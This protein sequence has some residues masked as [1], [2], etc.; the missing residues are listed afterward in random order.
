[1]IE[2]YAKTQKNIYNTHEFKM[3]AALQEQPHFPENKKNLHPHT[4]T[5]TCRLGFHTQPMV[6]NGAI[7]ENSITSSGRFD[8]K[9]P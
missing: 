5:T 9:K 2:L 6:P 7:E 1:M 8:L 4:C 3:Q